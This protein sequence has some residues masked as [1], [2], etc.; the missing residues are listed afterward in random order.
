M[1]LVLRVGFGC[2]K[3][4]LKSGGRSSPGQLLAMVLLEVP[5]YALNQ[6]LVFDVFKAVDIGEDK[7]LSK[8]TSCQQ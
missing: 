8:V 1:F 6:K 7:V 4:I 5:V 3:S 2:L